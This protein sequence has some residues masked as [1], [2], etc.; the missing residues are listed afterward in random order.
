MRYGFTLAEIL[1]TLLVMTIISAALVPLMYPSKVKV[2]KVITAHGLI[3]CFYDGAV[4]GRYLQQTCG[5]AVF[6]KLARQEF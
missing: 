1:I 6:R 2:E 4:A 5:R 3:E